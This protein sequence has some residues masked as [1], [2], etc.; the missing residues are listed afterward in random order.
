M[1]EILYIWADS[2]ALSVAIWLVI[3]ITLLYFGRPHAHQLL[4]STGRAVSS[5]LRLAAKSIRQLEDRVAARNRDVLLAAGREATER[6]VEREFARVHGIVERD[7]GE[8]PQLHRRLSDTLEKIE[9]DYQECKQEAPLPPEWSEVTSTIASLPT[10]GDPNAVR[11][12]E[13]IKAAVERSHKETLKAHQKNVQERHRILHGMQADWRSVSGSMEK[14]QKAV[15]SLDEQAR[16][17]DRHM[18]RYESIRRG[19]DRAVNA[20]TASSL[21]QFL[22]A[23]LVLGIAAFG[24]LVNFQLIAL[25]MSEMVGG[26]A[27]VGGMRA[28]DVAALVIIMVEISMGIFFLEA[29][30]ITNLFPMIARLDDRTRRRMAIAALTLLLLLACIESRT[31]LP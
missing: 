22:I 30:G 19:D 9:S 3:A 18:D 31:V 4:R 14:M 11:I 20:L 13:N 26:G 8:Y 6:A 24:G 12:L 28:A 5:S 23:G 15:T 16:A 25:P 21:T 27:Y 10:Q 2:P 7:L 29:V 17:I 1:S